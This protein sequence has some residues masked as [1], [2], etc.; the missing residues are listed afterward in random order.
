MISNNFCEKTCFSFSCNFI[1]GNFNSLQK[2]FIVWGSAFVITLHSMLFV[3]FVLVVELPVCCV[4]GAFQLKGTK[5][6]QLTSTQDIILIKMHSFS[7]TT[8]EKKLPTTINFN[9]VDLMS[10]GRHVFTAKKKKIDNV[11]WINESLVT[12]RHLPSPPRKKKPSARHFLFC[13]SRWINETFSQRITLCIC[14]KWFE[15]PYSQ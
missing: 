10:N 9:Y 15:L 1:F 3:F 6:L 11:L 14:L 2:H 12:F 7:H 13:R 5:K 8:N 4:G